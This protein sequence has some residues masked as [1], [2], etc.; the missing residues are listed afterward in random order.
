MAD[1]FNDRKDAGQRLADQLAV[2]GY[3][4]KLDL[5]VL[6][7]PRGG[8]PVAYEIAQKLKAPLDV[9]L[10]RKLGVP[11]QEELA[12]GA[13]APGDVVVL[14]DEICRL[15]KISQAHI[16]AII[17][18]EKKV[19]QERDEKYR[20]SRPMLD[21]HGKVVILVDDGIATGATMRAAIQALRTWKPQEI[22]VATPIIPEVSFDEIEAMADN[23]ICLIKPTEFIGISAFYKDFYQT[24]DEEVCSLLKVK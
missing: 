12:M 14:N 15:L 24:S 10:V 9:M 18:R 11:G 1:R 21:F 20:Q 23:V 2:Q 6:G 13:I 16:N 22:V 8:I 17:E 19:L 4:Q 5:V 3:D 7:L